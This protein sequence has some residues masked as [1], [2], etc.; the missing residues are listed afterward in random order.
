MGHDP[1]M[2]NNKV[3]KVPAEILRGLFDA[4]CRQPGGLKASQSLLS[5]DR[6]TKSGCPVTTVEKQGGVMVK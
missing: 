2:K 4:R 5:K 3:E 1:Q 6:D